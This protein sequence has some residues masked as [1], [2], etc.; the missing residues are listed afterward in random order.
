MFL[1]VPTVEGFSYVLPTHSSK[2]G[3]DSQEMGTLQPWATTVKTGEPHKPL[4]PMHAFCRPMGI[5]WPWYARVSRRRV[6]SILCRVAMLAI[7]FRVICRL[8]F[9]VSI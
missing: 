8:L 4:P 3:G 6:M 9:V 1:P 2:V 5:A 7:S